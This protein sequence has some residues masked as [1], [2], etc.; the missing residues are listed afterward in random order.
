MRRGPLW[1]LLAVLGG[2]WTSEPTVDGFTAAQWDHF[3][4]EHTLPAAANPC[5]VSVAITPF[6]TSECAAAATFG[7]KLFF[8]PKLSPKN[9]RVR[10]VPRSERVVQ[11]TAVLTT[12]S[13]RRPIGVTRRN[14]VSLV[15]LTHKERGTFTWIGEATSSVVIVNVALPKAMG[16]TPDFIEQALVGDLRYRSDYQSIFWR[17]QP[18]LGPES[19]YRGGPRD[20]HA[21]PHQRPGAVRSLPR[22]QHDGDLREREARFRAVRWPRHVHRVSFGTALHRRPRTRHGRPTSGPRRIP[23]ACSRPATPPTTASSSRHRYATSRRRSLHARRYPATLADVL[24]FYRWGGAT[25]GYL[26]DKDPLGRG[27]LISPTTSSGI[28]KSSSAPSP[29]TRSL[30]A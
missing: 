5:T 10:D 21:T 2:C 19:P 17:Q 20:V 25:T 3:R 4:T 29:A 23:A 16:T 6:N 8:E 7:Q 9:T 28:S 13:R 30:R 22:W 24:D 26:G 18:S 14:T 11:S 12:A 15:N 1:W 27:P